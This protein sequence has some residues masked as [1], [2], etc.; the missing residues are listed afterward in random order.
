MEN[1]KFLITAEI[2]DV[3]SGRD[4][5]IGTKDI[6]AEGKTIFE[7]VR[8]MIKTVGK[9]LYFCHAKIVVVS[10]QLA[11][12]SI[13]PVIDWITRDHEPRLTL[14]LL[15][16]DEKTARELLEKHAVTSEVL[17]YELNDML[18]SQK[19]LG[20]AEQ[21][22]SWQFMKALAADGISAT[23]PVARFKDEAAAGNETVA[24]I[25]G[26]AVFSGDREVAF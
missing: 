25:S 1:G 9:K 15:V 18:L 7:A 3:K 16:S 8:K 22:E 11:E 13:I 10:R 4:N 26:T 6:S 21:V 23:L 14:D 20:Y 17:S 12:E 24:E 2:I 5:S 19:N